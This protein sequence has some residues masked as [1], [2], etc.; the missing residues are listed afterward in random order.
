MARPNYR[1]QRGQGPQ[2]LENQFR[3]TLAQFGDSDASV[4]TSVVAIGTTETRIAHALGFTPI[5]WQVVAP[6]ALATVC[7]TKA[8]DGSFVY[9]KAS[10]AVN[11][12]V[13]VF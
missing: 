8:P 1:P 7:Q 4:L 11:A 9:L 3:D 2:A 5:G 12:R 6:D 10:A 13:R